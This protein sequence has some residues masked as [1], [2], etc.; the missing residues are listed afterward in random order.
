MRKV[1]YWATKS[2]GK[3]VAVTFHIKDPKCDICNKRITQDMQRL[4]KQHESAKCDCW[5]TRLIINLKRKFNKL[6]DQYDDLYM[7]MR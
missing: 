2:K 4:D 1:T 6:K 3:N 5:A 7:E